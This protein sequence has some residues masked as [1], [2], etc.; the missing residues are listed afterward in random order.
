[1]SDH[2][3]DSRPR[4]NRLPPNPQPGKGR[5]PPWLHRKLP[6]GGNLWKT[7]QAVG[8]QRLHTVC[9]EAR[10]P[11]LTECWSRKTATFLAMGKECTRACGFCSIDFAAQPKPLEADEPDRIVAS[12]KELGL[13]H[14]VITMVARDDLQDGGASQLVAIVQAIH[15]QCPDTTVELLTSDLGGNLEALDAVLQARPLIFNHNLETVRELTPRVRHKATYDRSLLLLAHAKRRG[16]QQFV[17]SGIMVGLGE[18]E[19]QVQQTLRDLA[20]AGVDTVTIG[21]YLQ[22]TNRKLLVREFIT[23]EQ[24]AT[25]ATYGREVGIPHMYCGPFVRSSYNADLLKDELLHHER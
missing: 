21:Q 9:E 8:E 24:F 5:F 19:S 11:N 12:V 6:K 13:R 18:T 15:A 23:P 25:Y 7:G 14:V 20:E 22:P 17:K 16:L 4:V 2:R 3:F 10:C 1:M